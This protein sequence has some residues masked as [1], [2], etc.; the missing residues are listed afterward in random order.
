MEKRRH[1]RLRSILFPG[2]AFFVLIYLHFSAA[3]IDETST[4]PGFFI[5]RN[6]INVNDLSFES[7]TNT[8]K[9]KW[10]VDTSGASGALLDVGVFCNTGGYPLF[11]MGAPD[12]VKL[13]TNLEDSIDLKLGDRLL[14]DTTYYISLLLRNR[15][16][17]WSI[18]ADS[19][20]GILQIPPFTSQAVRYGAGFPT[21]YANN[22]TIKI[23][24]D[25]ATF[26][27]EEIDDNRIV[28]WKPPA[29]PSGFIP[30]SAGFEF[31]S[32]YQSTPLSIGVKYN[33]LP[34]GYSHAHVRIYRFKNGEWFLDRRPFLCDSS[35]RYVSVLTGDISY[36]FIAMIDTQPPGVSVFSHPENA[37]MNGKAVADT[38]MITDNISNVRWRFSYAKAGDSFDA[39][40]GDSG[41]LEN[42]FGNIVTVIQGSFVSAAQGVRAVLVTSDGVNDV[43]RNVSRK[44]I[45]NIGGSDVVSLDT[46]KWIP[47]SVTANLDNP[48]V[49]CALKIFNSDG[50]W[51]YDNTKFR[52]FRWVA[53]SG[54]AGGKAH[55]IEYA[56]SCDSLFSFIPGRLFWIKTRQSVVIDFG[57]GITPELTKPSVVT[58]HARSWTDF[59]LPFNFNIKVG[60]ILDST[61]A[62][63]QA[64]EG[65]RFCVW[66]CDSTKHYLCKEFYTPQLGVIGLKDL[67]KIMTAKQNDGRGA[68]Y[69]VFN[70][71][72]AD[73]N[74][75]IPPLP[76]A[77]SKY[78]GAIPKETAFDVNP[79]IKITSRTLSGIVLNDIYCVCKHGNAGNRYFPAA[80]SLG[81]G[82]NVRVCDESMRQ[83]GHVIAGMGEAPA[84]G[85]ACNL[86]FN[87]NSNNAEVIQVNVSGLGH[88]RSELYN[89]V[90]GTF[91][92]AAQGMS[93][94]WSIDAAAGT[95]VYYQLLAGEDAFI[96]KA[97][98][99]KKPSMA[100]LVGVYPDLAKQSVRIRF[101]LQM[102]QVSVRVAIFDLTGRKLW[103]ASHHSRE[104]INEIEWNGISLGKRPA[105]SGAY[106]L[107]MLVYDVK[108]DL[109]AVF[110]KKLTLLL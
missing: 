72:D 101:S 43:I 37:V 106:I 51:K 54:R 14:F 49:R 44:V 73:V 92:S 39:A 15:G 3:G 45:R 18:F 62:Y 93:D 22:K 75:S 24:I 10:T 30:V 56:D 20:R 89:P 35:Q 53:E 95:T 32:K 85:V 11:V 33:T 60:D 31:F 29:S 64:I 68:G 59:A 80:P 88:L 67:S 17:G 50:Q 74:L 87:N 55:Y 57:N 109:S 65:L 36:P 61:K 40:S 66:S 77:M 12:T 58:L 46:M 48:Q 13:N 42:T 26:P 110:E 71:S 63:G 69:C 91:F 34:Y 23:S 70:N 27:K 103:D 84:E 81:G 100:A 90:N 41:M 99:E 5:V 86:A 98:F 76:A 19:A 4:A 102:G 83:Y 97:E 21:A 28:R 47:L 1:H 6:T 8:I 94:G 38:F 2:H 108:G 105:A 107:R 9:I 78:K 16:G 52:L 104:G 79:T 25:P 7:M 96:K 82:V